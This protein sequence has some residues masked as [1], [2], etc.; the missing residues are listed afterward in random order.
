[1]SRILTPGTLVQA[2][3]EKKGI[4][5]E[6]VK[7]DRSVRAMRATLNFNMIPKEKYP[8]GEQKKEVE[9]ELEEKKPKEKDPFIRVFD[10]DKNDW[11]G[12]RFSSITNVIIDK[13]IFK[14]KA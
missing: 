6:F 14:I 1:M 11:R 9:K 7:K 4:I 3:K 12:F 10:L 2:L 5:V 13:V 8:K